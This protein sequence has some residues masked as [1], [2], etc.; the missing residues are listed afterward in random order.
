MNSLCLW[1]VS[2]LYLI[3]AAVSYS[4]SMPAASVIMLGYVVANLGLI[5]AIHTG[6]A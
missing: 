6:A 5:W 1:I 3:Q 4:N 2:A